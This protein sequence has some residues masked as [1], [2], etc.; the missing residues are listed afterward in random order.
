MSLP[1]NHMVFNHYSRQV[2]NEKGQIGKKVIQNLQCEEIRDNDNPNI[3]AEA[4]A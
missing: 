3:G 4:C 2:Y 1:Y